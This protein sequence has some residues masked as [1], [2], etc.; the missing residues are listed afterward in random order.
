M[1]HCVGCHK[2]GLVSVLLAH[3]R[4][5]L[6]RTP[7]DREIILQIKSLQEELSK[8]RIEHEAVSNPD[9]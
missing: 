4:Q 9:N 3:E 7:D 8:L 2:I 1:A 5:K 6:L